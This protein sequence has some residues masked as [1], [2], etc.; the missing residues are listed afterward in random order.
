MTT[1]PQ[2]VVNAAT[3][4]TIIQTAVYVLG[5][6]GANSAQNWV[7][8]HTAVLIAVGVAVLNV[9]GDLLAA[10]HA[11]QKVTPVED[12]KTVDGT[13]LAPVTALAAPAPA[14]P[15]VVVADPTAD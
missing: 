8:T 5:I 7:D 4:K 15:G 3:F 2:P 14:D 12:P 13:P 6:L 1:R 10:F 9:G 11:Q